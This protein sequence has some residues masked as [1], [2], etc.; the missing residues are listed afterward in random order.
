VNGNVLDEKPSPNSETFAESLQI[1]DRHLP[2]KA[3][4]KLLLLNWLE[5]V[6][7]QFCSYFGAFDVKSNCV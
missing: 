4:I 5:A 1:A 2:Y 3:E 7:A 6:Y